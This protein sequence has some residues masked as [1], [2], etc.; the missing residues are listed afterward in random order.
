MRR[1]VPGWLRTLAGEPLV[2]FA[3]IGGLLF[4]LFA[5]DG[6]A[7]VEPPSQRI[8]VDASEVQRL[9]VPFEK[10]WLR[11][12][13]QAE[14]EGLVA[15]HIKEEILY[16]EAKALG[17]D[18]DDLII[19]RR[20]RQKMEFINQDLSVPREP[21]DAELEQYLQAN[22]DHYRGADRFSFEQ[23][24]LA[25]GG[26]DVATRAARLL[27]ELHAAQDGVAVAGA[28]GDPTLLPARMRE[29]SAAEA[30]RVFGSAFSD[31]LAEMPVGAWAGPYTS[32]FGVHLVRVTARDTAT[33]PTLA[34]RRTAL[35]RDW[36]AAQRQQ[37]DER[38]YQAIRARYTVRVTYPNAASDASPSR[39]A[40]Q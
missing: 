29:A 26:E 37:A 35:V 9:I 25:G 31:R 30:A 7:V 8:I 38:L 18:D 6:D 12:P 19:R 33:A 17:L 24:F 23:V 1:S 40:A 13:T 3:V 36:R 39:V 4:V 34:N 21:T 20:L 28:A 15:D 10:T 14:I 27:R 2:H 22:L 16:R 5:V 32:T 11:P